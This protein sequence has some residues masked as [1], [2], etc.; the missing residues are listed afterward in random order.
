MVTVAFCWDGTTRSVF[1]L[2]LNTV[3]YLITRSH[4]LKSSTSSNTFNQ[5]N[6]WDQGVTYLDRYLQDSWQNFVEE[7][8]FSV[9]AT[10][11]IDFVSRRQRPKSCA[12]IRVHQA[13]SPFL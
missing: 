9:D 12:L 11:L 4:Q 5:F 10:N 6:P 7:E 8:D 13:G 2:V 1:L 3:L